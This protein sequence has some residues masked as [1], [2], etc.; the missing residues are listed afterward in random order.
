V[1]NSQPTA[2]NERMQF[3]DTQTVIN[4]FAAGMEYRCAEPTSGARVE[5]VLHE[6]IESCV[7]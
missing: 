3:N 7:R 5:V 4:Q 1:R 2:R 6:L